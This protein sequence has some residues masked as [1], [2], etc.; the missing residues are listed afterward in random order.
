[1]LWHADTT[2]CQTFEVGTSG[3]TTG[4]FFIMCVGHLLASLLLTAT[5]PLDYRHASR[6][7]QIFAGVLGLRALRYCELS[8]VLTELHEVH[9]R[10]PDLLALRRDAQDRAP[11]AGSEVDGRPD[12]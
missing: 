2:F 10:R 12:W 6:A 8:P 5:L 4:T 11:L 7:P 3:T 9:A 1:M